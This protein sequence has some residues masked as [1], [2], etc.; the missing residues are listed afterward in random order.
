MLG[1]KKL[2]KVVAFGSSG[3]GKTTLVRRIGSSGRKAG[4]H[5][6]GCS[7][8]VA[9]DLSVI[10]GEH[11]KVYLYST[12]GSERFQFVAKIVAT[13]LNIG[14]LIVDS[15]RKMTDYEKTLLKELK[16]KGIPFIIVANKADLPGFSLENIRNDIGPNC[17]VLPV[18]ATAG[19]GTDT[20]VN[21]IMD[22]ANRLA[23][24]GLSTSALVKA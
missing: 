19:Y 15:S 6:N 3:S 17:L 8:T 12:P 10:D 18:S 9:F 11:S 7:A 22:I 1:F 2:V 20:L 5:G 14:L 24:K 4:Y 21:T 13:G 23:P 16:S